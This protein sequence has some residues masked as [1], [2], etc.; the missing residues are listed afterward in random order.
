MFSRILRHFATALKIPN[1]STSPSSV[2][3][4][5]RISRTFDD[6][7]HLEGEVAH[8]RQ[9]VKAATQGTCRSNEEA[10]Q[11]FWKVEC[12]QRL[13]MLKVGDL[14][15]PQQSIKHTSNQRQPKATKGNQSWKVKSGKDVFFHNNNRNS[16]KEARMRGGKPRRIRARGVGGGRRWSVFPWNFGGIPANF[17]SRVP[18]NCKT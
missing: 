12:G 13:A 6:N 7:S 16:C 1:F 8:S 18:I 17:V 9:G 3:V 15:H 11:T 2:G 10:A 4:S 5:W 14:K